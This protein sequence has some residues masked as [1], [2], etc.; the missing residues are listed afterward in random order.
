MQ[1]QP[2]LPEILY[3]SDPLCGWCYS[4]SPTIQRIQQEWAGRI[5]VSVLC[6]GMVT[7]NQVGPIGEDWPDL[8]AGL[9]QVETVTGVPFGAGFRALGAAGTY[10]QNSEPP[11]RAIHAFRQLRQEHTARFA[12]D[13][14]R[15]YFHDG[16]D[17]NDMGTY[18]PL[19]AAYGVDMVN[20]RRQLALPETARGTQ[21][22]FA[23]VAKIGVQGF[24][25]CILRV[26]Q[27]GYVLARGYQP[28]EVFAAGLE[29]AL[30]QA[31]EESR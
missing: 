5:E 20:F 26:G 8:E 29:Q 23:A 9:Q 2:D 27:Q 19:A 1:H 18:E 17:L 7:G 10:V 4:M 3:I 28:Y 25:T 12:H 21:L 16:A 14:Q 30:M 24:P 15:A 31:E 13:V 11:C 22:E 6:G